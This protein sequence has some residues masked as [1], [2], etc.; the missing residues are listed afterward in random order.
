MPEVREV[1][2]TDVDKPLHADCCRVLPRLKCCPFDDH[3]CSVELWPGGDQRKP[4]IREL[5]YTPQRVR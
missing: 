4:A 1:T 5:T 2:L 3:G